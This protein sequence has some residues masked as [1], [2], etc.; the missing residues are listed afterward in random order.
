[1]LKNRGIAIF[2]ASHR[3]KH[4]G[5]S[6]PLTEN[7]FA[8]NMKRSWM[9]LAAV[10]FSLPVFSQSTETI[11]NR[12]GLAPTGIWGGSYYMYSSH[13]ED[14]VYNRGG[15]ID[16]EF[17]RSLE[18]GWAWERYKEN[19]NIEGQPGSFSLRHNGLHLALSPNSHKVLHPRISMVVGGGRLKLSD[20]TKD[21]VFVFHPQAGLEV[22]VFRWLKMG[23]EG[24][25]R[26]VG[27]TDIDVIESSDVSAPTVNI[28]VRYGFS[29]GG[30][31]GN[32]SF[33][34]D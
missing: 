30:N 34:W 20:D 6:S 18:I 22:N 29:W 32:I 15:H 7:S 24:G 19:A 16:L 31:D 26:F 10:L 21:R 14:W 13:D 23:I 11:F 12:I 2:G 27:G 1:M 3:Q 5:V 8:M 17:G 33:D 9:I 28:H 4:L 25:Y